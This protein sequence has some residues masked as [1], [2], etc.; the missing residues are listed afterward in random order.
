MFILNS[1]REMVLDLF[2]MA[3]G[4]VYGFVMVGGFIL[5]CSAIVYA[6]FVLIL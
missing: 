5:V 2:A 4:F 1:I 6:V 3:K